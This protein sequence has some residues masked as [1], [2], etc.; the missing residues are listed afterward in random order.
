M[1]TFVGHHM[2]IR[3]KIYGAIY[4]VGDNVVIFGRARGE[5]EEQQQ[6]KTRFRLSSL[7][8]TC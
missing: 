5:E 2:K 4:I 8:A 1:K 7:C 3:L 6:K